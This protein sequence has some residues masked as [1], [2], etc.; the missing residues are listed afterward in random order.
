MAVLGINCAGRWTNV[1]VADGGAILAET[2]RE[3]ARRQSELLPSITEETLAAAGVALGD[4][5]LVA[6][7]TGPGYYTGIRA[8]IAYGAA[9]ARALG[10]KAVPLSSLELFVW[11]M[12][13]EYELLAPVFR[14]R[15][16]HSYAALYES[17]GGAL[18]E[19]I[20]PCVIRVSAHAEKLAAY[21]YPAIVSPALAQCGCAVV[22]RESAS[23]GA[24]AVMGGG[25]A[26][27]AVA[28]E[29]IRGT[30]LRAPDIGPTSL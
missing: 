15:T 30:Y 8:G 27:L 11:D 22:P 26:A 21:T 9:L 17:R 16:S 3:L 29:L 10:V 25:R 4:I 18:N 14:A 19:V 28:P 13:D 1:G 20:A 24:C 12:R 2:N 23:G 7:G 6:L 5:S